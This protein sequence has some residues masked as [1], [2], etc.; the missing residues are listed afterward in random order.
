D[1]TSSALRNEAVR[2]GE[3]DPGLWR[4]LAGDPQR[5]IEVALDSME[6]GAWDDALGLLGRRY[7]TGDGVFAEAGAPA[8]QEHPEVAYYRG[9]CRE[10]L[11]G[12]GRADFDAA[13]TMDT[14]YVFPHRAASLPVL[15]RALESNPK[16]ATA[17]FLLGSLHLSGGLAHAAVTEWDEA[18]RLR[19]D[20]KV[21][22]RN[23]GL[24]L[25]HATRDL[26]RALDVLREGARVDPENVQVH[27]ALDQVLGLLGR[28]AEERLA[29]LEAY[30]RLEA[31]PAPLVFKRVLALVEVGRFE[32]AERA[33]AGRFFPREEFGTNVRQVFVEARIQ[34]ALA[35]ARAQDC[36]AARN[37]VAAIG[38]E[39]AGL[40]FTR[41]GLSAFADTARIQY[42]AGEV[43]ASCGDVPAAR[44][45]WERAAAAADAYPQP[46]LAFALAAARR[47]GGGRPDAVRLRVEQAL[48]AWANRLRVGTNFPGPNAC[49]QGLMLLALGRDGEAREKL[50]EALRLPDRILSHY[51]SRAALRGEGGS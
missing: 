31:L 14:T 3:D 7:P 32:D 43:Q 48:A 8:P 38:S 46:N 20:L 1:P 16:D 42:L 18:R 37:L 49:G 25:L 41:D 44:R 5:V 24:T 47:L 15:R 2:L 34:K 51:L 33:L 12:S 10:K 36:G 27:E 28:P 50:E 9:F 21:L 39:A 30:P 45:H 17:H 6:L 29:A 35:R 40:P 4:H 26:P 19:P 22:H 13:S 11:G 23:L